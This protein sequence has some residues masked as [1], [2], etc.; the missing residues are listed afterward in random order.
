M[1]TDE[2]ED[3]I[4]ERVLHPFYTALK[5]MNKEERDIAVPLILLAAADLLRDLSGTAAT[6]AFYVDAIN[7]MKS[8][9]SLTFERIE[10]MEDDYANS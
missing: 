5:Y 8:P 6:V 10:S 1:L 2:E 7:D 3:A 4:G 9:P